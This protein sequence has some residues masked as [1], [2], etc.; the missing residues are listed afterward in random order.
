MSKKIPF[1]PF[2]FYTKYIPWHILS[3][4]WVRPML[5]CYPKPHFSINRLN[6]PFILLRTKITWKWY[7]KI[8]ILA[9]GCHPDW[10]CNLFLIIMSCYLNVYHRQKCHLSRLVL[11]VCITRFKWSKNIRSFIVKLKS[12]SSAKI[13]ELLTESTGATT[14]FVDVHIIHTNPSNLSLTIMYGH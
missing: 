2:S 11:S 8:E 6:S 5:D 1:I 13:R 7:I 12:D 3:P 10:S 9:T 4:T 14:I